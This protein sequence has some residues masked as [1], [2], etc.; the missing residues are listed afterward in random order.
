MTSWRAERL[1]VVDIETTGLDPARHEVLSVGVVDVVRGR[2]QVGS[3]W[4]REVR[5][6]VAPT[7][8][9]VVVHGIR[10]TDSARG[11]DPATVAAEV[12]ARLDGRRLVAHVARIETAFLGS[13]L[14]DGRWRPAL[15][16][17]DTDVLARRHLLRARGMRLDQHIGLGA[18]AGLFGLPEH[19]RHHALGDALTT[20]Q[21][22]LALASCWPD[23]DP[24]GDQLARASRR[25]PGRVLDRVLGR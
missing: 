23:G 5:P 21:L 7:A 14:E 12:A 16:V 9:T 10:P 17:I 18:A 25:L 11:D 1:A 4:Y 22:L 19:A 3:A 6:R 24:S 8:D 15:G 13:W 20:A 2:V